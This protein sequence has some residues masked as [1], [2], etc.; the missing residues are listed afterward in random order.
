MCYDVVID[1]LSNYGARVVQH[2]IKGTADSN[3]YIIVHRIEELKDAT[4]YGHL[5]TDATTKSAITITGHDQ[6]FA[7]STNSG[8]LIQRGNT[9]M[10]RRPWENIIITQ[11]HGVVNNHVLNGN[12]DYDTFGYSGGS[13]GIPSPWLFNG[14]TSLEPVRADG[15]AEDEGIHLL[16]NNS[17]LGGYIYQTMLTHGQSVLFSL[18]IDYGHKTSAGTSTLNIKGKLIAQNSDADA[19]KYYWDGSSWG[20]DTTFSIVQEASATTFSG[21]KTFE[22]FGS[23]PA[24]TK[25][26]FVLQ[27]YEAYDPGS[28]CT[29]YF[30]NVELRFYDTNYSI[31]TETEYDVSNDSVTSG[32]DIELEV[33]NGDPPIALG[34]RIY[35]NGIYYLSGT[36][37]YTGA[38]E[39]STR[40][41][42]EED[43]I[44][45][46]V[47]GEIAAQ[48]ARSYQLL[49]VQLL[50]TDDPLYLVG[51]FEDPLNQYWGVNRLFYFNRARFNARAASWDLE[52]LEFIEHDL[53]YVVDSNSDNVIDNLGNYVT[54]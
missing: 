20:V 47:Y 14:V 7:R 32:E 45:E 27:L 43:P 44:I 15:I 52:L 11:D 28:V 3:F 31:I 5:F 37:A 22:S 36:G 25:K 13:W 16:D 26:Y 12:F 24:V 35:R 4:M 17:S 53:T 34:D 33:T 6:E 46:L 8:T 51:T 21:W 2:L 50:E 54:A 19:T 42:S 48:H 40:D 29:S 39:W 10:L 23:D 1:V 41:G 30:K 49:D 18:R 38:S 9:V